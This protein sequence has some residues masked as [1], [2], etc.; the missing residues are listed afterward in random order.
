MKANN[1]KRALPGINELPELKIIAEE[2]EFKAVP[3]TGM[4]M[5]CLLT[6]S[7]LLPE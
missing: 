6:M 2:K 7:G 5:Q 1:T 3:S 4:V